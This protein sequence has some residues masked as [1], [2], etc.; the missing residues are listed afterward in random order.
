MKLFSLLFTLAGFCLALTSSNALA[1]ELKFSILPKFKGLRNDEPIEARRLRRAAVGEII[2]REQKSRGPT[3]LKVGEVVFEVEQEFG[4]SPKASE[5]WNTKEG[6]PH[7][8]QLKGD[9]IRFEQLG[10]SRWIDR[11]KLASF[12]EVDSAFSVYIRDHTDDPYAWQ[13]RAV[14]RQI[15]EHLDDAISD[16]TQAI[17]IK[18][19]NAGFYTYRAMLWI[20]FKKE[21]KPAIDDCNEAHRL[22]PKNPEPIGLRATAYVVVSNNLAKA[23]P[24]FEEAVRLGKKDSELFAMCGFIKSAEGRLKEGVADYTAALEVLPV[25]ATDHTRKQFTYYCLRAAAHIELDEI[26]AAIADASRAIELEPTIE[27]LYSNRADLQCQLGNYSKAIEDCDRA[28]T[29]NPDL[30]EAR[31][32]RGV[33]LIKL[34]ELD[35]AIEA[36]SEVLRQ[37]ANSFDAYMGRGLARHNKK[38]FDLAIVD[39]SAAARLRRDDKTPLYWRAKCW[40]AKGDNTK[41]EY[42]LKAMAEVE[43]V[44]K[45]QQR[46]LENLRR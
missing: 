4:E 22:E 2:A 27:I 7:V 20:F 43:N 40:Q 26:E 17:R 15:A 37:N 44:K 30:A 35:K 38:D 16:M 10:K 18:P 14:Y 32:N 23:L 25:D 8:V 1:K 29:L 45:E 31:V 5:M 34:G 11:S 19:Q 28:L 36:F 39:F 6:G 13:H 41:A 12:S 9:S 21:L 46:F 42:D 3:E 24:D 33:A